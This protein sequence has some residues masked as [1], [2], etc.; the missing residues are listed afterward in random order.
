MKQAVVLALLLPEDTIMGMDL[1][2]GRYLTHGSVVNIS[3]IWSKS[4]SYG[5]WS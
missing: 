2:W 5:W 3:R 1:K 4:I